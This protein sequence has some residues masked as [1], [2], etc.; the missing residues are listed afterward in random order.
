M[1]NLAN[2]NTVN[3]RAN[4]SARKAKQMPQGVQYAITTVLPNISNGAF[5][6]FTSMREI[7]SHVQAIR[8]AAPNIVARRLNNACLIEVNPTYLLQ[9]VQAI[10][11]EAIGQQELNDIMEA[12]ASAHL[13]FE[14]FLLARGKSSAKT[15]KLWDG[16]I[17]I[18]C[19]NDVTSI[20]SKGIN[21]PAF[22]LNLSDVLNYLHTYGYTVEVG[23]R[24]IP[25]ASAIRIQDNSLW[26]SLQLSPTKTGIFMRVACTYRAE[27]FKALEDNF[28]A[29][30]K[31]VK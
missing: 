13:A 26:D 1:A 21:Y 6:G 23:G 2:G 27:Q 19:T 31:P 14:K 8:E 20:A 28:K 24:M 5:W 18:Y 29:R 7:E 3:D 10:D 25:A 17:G 22:R 15:G 30:S 9:A 16:I 11:P 12:K 4:E